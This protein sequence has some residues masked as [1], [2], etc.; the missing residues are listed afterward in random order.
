MASDHIYRFGSDFQFKESDKPIQR[1]FK[2]VA[3]VVAVSL[4]VTVVLYTAFAIFVNTDVEGRLKRENKMYE[5]LYPQLLPQQ[6]LLED[7]IS[8]L[9]IKDNAIYEEVFHG[10]APS[11]DP[12]NS[13]PFIGGNDSI[14][15]TSLIA[16]SSAKSDRMVE[17][18]AKVEQNLREAL[19]KVANPTFVCPPMALPVKNISFTQVG[20]STGER[21][22][23]YL[24]AEIAHNGLDLIVAQG[25][26]VLASGSGKVSLV[27]KSSKGD[28]N[29]IVINHPGGYQTRYCH[30]S[31]MVVKQGENVRAGQ[32]IG[33][34]GTTGTAFAP[35]LHYEVIFN[36]VKMDPINYIF[37]SVTPEEYANMLYMAVNTRQSMD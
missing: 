9:E 14:P 37:A 18:A 11:V 4:V 1:I 6:E 5:K 20:A 10:T 2:F 15:N 3:L 33:T 32:K 17:D 23:P 34:V 21:L 7:A 19:L 16:F 22:N 25:E 13:L 26:P 31:T 8:N 29:V 36:G 28:G 35:H 12:I 27:E 24:K 30:L